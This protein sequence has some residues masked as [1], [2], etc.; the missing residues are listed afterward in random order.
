MISPFETNVQNHSLSDIIYAQFLVHCPG[1]KASLVKQDGSYSEFP[2]TPRPDFIELPSGVQ[3]T[4]LAMAYLTQYGWEMYLAGLAKTELDYINAGA[5]EIDR[6]D[7]ETR[8]KITTPTPELQRWQPPA[9][10]LL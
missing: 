10:S 8:I 2:P 7:R 6:R 3:I 4:T 5:V 9:G 1:I